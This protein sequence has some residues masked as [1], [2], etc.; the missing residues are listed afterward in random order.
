MSLSAVSRPGVLRLAALLLAALVFIAGC[1]ATR[2]P[3][4][5]TAADVGSTLSAAAVTLRAAH[6]GRVT[7][8]YAQGSFVNYADQLV[9]AADEL[10]DL[11]G[12]PDP[13]MIGRL[14]ELLGPAAAVSQAPCLE[15]PCDVQPQLDA[16]EVARDAFI[17]ASMP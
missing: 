2:S 4:S 9:G 7:R 14:V 17:Q 6:E 12:A 11:E 3:F 8:E 1:S 16:L 15:G 10:A 5:R 13:G